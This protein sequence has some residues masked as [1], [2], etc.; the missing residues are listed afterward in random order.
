M[1][2]VVVHARGNEMVRQFVP[3]GGGG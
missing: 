3:D 1:T 2:F